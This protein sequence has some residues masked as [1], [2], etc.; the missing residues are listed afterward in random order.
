MMYYLAMLAIVA[1][2]IAHAVVLGR[3]IDMENK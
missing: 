3:K 2:V 1:A